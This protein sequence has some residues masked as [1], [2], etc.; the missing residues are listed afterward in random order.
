MRKKFDD[1][2]SHLDT[3]YQPDGQ[4]DTKWQQRLCLRIA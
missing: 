2:F 1:I 4:T 3:I